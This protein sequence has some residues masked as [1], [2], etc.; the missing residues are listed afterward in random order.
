MKTK[1]TLLFLLLII[2][3]ACF[4]WGIYRINERSPNWTGFYYRNVGQRT[5][6]ISFILR[7]PDIRSP[8]GAFQTIEACQEWAKS[9]RMKQQLE[10]TYSSPQTTD[11]Q[12]MQD[13]LFYCSRQCLI[14]SGVGGDCKDPEAQVF[15]FGK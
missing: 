5:E 3:L 2:G 15:L 7:T 12:Y 8:V 14:R 9:I 13:D 6:P 11:G 4:S 10:R 1:H